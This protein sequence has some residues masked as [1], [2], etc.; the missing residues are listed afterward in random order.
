MALPPCPCIYTKVVF[1]FLIL[2]VSLWLCWSSLLHGLFSS[3]GEWELLCSCGARAF[4]CG[5]FSCCRAR[6][7]GCSGFSRCST[8]A[9][10]LWPLG[11]VAVESSWI[12]DQAHVPWIE[13]WTPNQWTTWEFLGLF[14]LII[15]ATT[16][17]SYN[18]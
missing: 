16:I 7:L 3:C 10:Q 18:P 8:W 17:Y 9:Q 2:F 5:G 13:R 6:V 14:S 11:L 15:H 4:P 1:F 12:R